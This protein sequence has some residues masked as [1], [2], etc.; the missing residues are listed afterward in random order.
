[1]RVEDGA[2]AFWGKKEGMQEKGKLESEPKLES[3]VNET[4]SENGVGEG[5]IGVNQT[6]ASG[7]WI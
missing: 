3:C 6:N 5:F 1:M 2:A 4:M 7:H